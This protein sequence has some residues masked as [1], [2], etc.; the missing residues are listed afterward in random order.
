MMERSGLAPYI[1]LT[2]SNE[3]VINSKPDPEMYNKAMKYF[4]LLPKECLIL[5]DNENGILAAK[6]SGGNLLVI[7]DVHETN[8]ANILAA[9]SAAEQSNA[10]NL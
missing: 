3:D 9:I 2:I 4:G 1:D 10:R 6:A 7:N 8:Y 5:E